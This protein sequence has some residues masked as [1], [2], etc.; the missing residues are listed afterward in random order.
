MPD[1][2]TLVQL[3]E[4]FDVKVDDLIRDPEEIPEIPADPLNM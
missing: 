3:A 4:L 2:L 1:V